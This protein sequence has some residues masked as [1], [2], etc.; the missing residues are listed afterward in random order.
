MTP[1]HDNT[2][3]IALEILRS[4]VKLPPLP[5]VLTRLLAL[6]RQP[7][8]RIDV[9]KFTK[10]LQTD[11]ALTARI[12][13]LANSTYYGTM[14]RIINL[15]QAVMHIGLQ[16]TISM[17]NWM[18]CQKILPQFPVIEGFSDKDYWAHS[19]ACATANRMLGRPDL[20]V[21]C[22]PGELYVVGLLHGIGKLI[23][24]LHK[25]AEFKQC[26]D[27]SR[28][29]AQPLE[30][31]ELDILG[32]TDAHIACEILKTWQF[33]D[34]ICNAVKYFRHPEIAEQQFREIAALTQ[35]A[36]FIA[37]TSGIGNNGDEF[38]FDIN[39]TYLAGQSDSPLSDPE[40][41][42]RLV[43]D[44]QQTLQQKATAVTGV[45]VQPRTL[46]EPSPADEFRERPMMV[47]K[48]KKPGFFQRLSDYFRKIIQ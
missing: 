32:T 26:L 14:T 21:N 37:T 6:S 46:A 30:E 36:Y 4:G 31:A 23:L 15:K 28:D 40:T 13:Q 19:W 22:Q 24:A 43:H 18:L 25:P 20:L 10:L 17:V 5:A 34:S 41:R 45:T 44:I 9:N 38:S 47:A 33:P 35:F 12:L 8:D 27:N 42:D 48:R 2:E 7:E 3:R 16:E 1:V 39:E 11:P 29:F